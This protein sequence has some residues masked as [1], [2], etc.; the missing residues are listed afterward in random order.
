[1]LGEQATAWLRRQKVLLVTSENCPSCKNS[2]QDDVP[3]ALLECT[4]HLP[5]RDGYLPRT[6]GL[7]RNKH[8]HW[9]QIWTGT[10]WSEREISTISRCYKQPTWHPTL[11]ITQPAPV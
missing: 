11:P 5:I 3:H 8:P 1:M 4:R 7:M 6:H 9:D 2:L 10:H